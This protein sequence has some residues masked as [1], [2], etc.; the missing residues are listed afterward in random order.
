MIPIA[1]LTR[2]PLQIVRVDAIAY[3]AKDTGEMG[4]G[5]ASSILV[6][7]GPEV[8]AAAKLKMAKSTRGVGEV[9]ITDAFNLQSLGVRWI[10]HIISIIKHTPQGAYCPAP[11]RLGD[12]VARALV[13]VSKLG[14]RS[15]AIS[16]LGTGEGRV[17]P[18]LAARYMFNGVH[19]FRES[20]PASKLAVIF[21]LPSFRDYE[22]FSSVMSE[23]K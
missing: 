21:S 22:A 18:R 15:I 3:G 11:E 6:A 14:A 10:V 20:N 5:A 8:L 12:G 4:G 16:A 17:E 2:D 19:A 13:E 7:A 1:S 9:V 23:S